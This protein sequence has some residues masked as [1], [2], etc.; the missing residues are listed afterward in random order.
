MATFT[1]LLFLDR[2]LGKLTIDIGMEYTLT[3]TQC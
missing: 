3:A 1:V 2:A